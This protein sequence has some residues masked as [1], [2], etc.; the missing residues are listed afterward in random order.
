VVLTERPPP[1]TGLRLL[2]PDAGPQKLS[3]KGIALGA[4]PAIG[5]ELPGV[6]DVLKAVSVAFEKKEGN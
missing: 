6:G 3:K 2:G 4:L 5:V 1:P